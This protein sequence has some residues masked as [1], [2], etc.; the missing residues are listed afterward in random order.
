[1]STQ[2]ILFGVKGQ[3]PQKHRPLG[4][5]RRGRTDTIH[6]QMLAF[7]QA[8]VGFQTCH[9]RCLVLVLVVH[10]FYFIDHI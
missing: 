6:A 2:F 1:M 8:V 10:N 5:T 9:S 7:H 4:V 3:V